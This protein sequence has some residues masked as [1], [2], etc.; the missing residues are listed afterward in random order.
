M[1]IAD[2]EFVGPFS[3]NEK[4]L[5]E[6]GAIYLISNDEGPLYIGITNNL[7]ERLRQH[8]ARLT[9]Q[10]YEKGSLLHYWPFN[11]NQIFEARTL[12]TFLISSLRPTLN[13]ISDSQATGIRF[14]ALVRRIL[15]A[16]EFT[17][18]QLSARTFDFIA[19]LG[20]EEWA[21]EVKYYR[22]ARAQI[23]LIEAAAAQ[24]VSRAINASAWKGMLVVSCSIPPG[25]REE[26]ERLYSVL[27]VDRADLVIWASKVPE[28]LDE[29]SALLDSDSS[30]E[31]P[32]HGRPPSAIA[33]SRRLPTSSPPK[34][35][36]G[37]DLC[38]ELHS[39]KPGL[40]NWS[41]Y[42]KLC[43]RILRY[44]FPNDLYGWH[45]QART[46]D[47]FSRF[48]YVC[49]IQSATEF[50]RLLIDHLN[51]RYVIFEFK[52][53]KGKIKQGQV[54]TTEKYLLEK[55]LRRAAILITRNGADKGAYAMIQGA[56]REHGKLML[57][58]DDEKVCKMLHMKE[59]GEDPTDLLFDEVDDFL[60]KLPR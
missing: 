54:L 38:N 37:T 60:I 7:R 9:F 46:E 27:F 17:V 2:K 32:S 42:E 21:V 45:K 25:A 28:L 13:K 48:D 50:W 11:E 1:K 51:S 59:N 40:K 6:V 29:L 33:S 23:S 34:S 14:E 22:T 57:V 53:Y 5:P 41:A 10:D 20:N 12:E 4:N 35:T 15:V 19:Q 52:N 58:V 8:R 26:L 39:M 36:E 49:R 31:S 16:N 18:Q 56:M 55:G 24:L 43:D 3:L 44:L 30:A 47:G